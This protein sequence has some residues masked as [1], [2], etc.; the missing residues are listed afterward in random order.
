MKK[1]T[2]WIEDLRPSKLE[3][4]IGNDEIKAD[5]KKYLENNDIPHLLFS[6]SPGTGKTTLAKLIVGNLNCDWEYLNASDENGIETIREKVKKIAESASFKPLKIIILDEAD[7]LTQPAQAALRNLIE[8]YSIST[9]FILT[10]NYVEKITEAL[11]SRCTH[12]KILPPSKLVVAKYLNKVLIDKKIK[13]ELKIIAPLINSYYPDIRS[14]IKIAQKSCQTGEFIW[15]QDNLSWMG[16]VVEILKS[17]SSKAW[18]DIR[19]VVADSQA[20]DFQQAYKHLW[21]HLGEYS[22]GNDAQIS[23][24]LDE[25]S[26][27]AN[28]VSDKELNLAACI[29][30]ILETSKKQVI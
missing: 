16:K 1:N 13:V 3:D 7:F 5:I 9:R 25:Y 20:T 8:E 30:K 18:Y 23:I 22:W 2:L 15:T 24:V 6:G 27:R 10:C 29:A 14:I 28:I 12:Y 21:D 11:Q 4:Y 17:R 19:Q 26:Y